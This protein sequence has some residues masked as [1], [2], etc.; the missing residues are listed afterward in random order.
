MLRIMQAEEIASL[1]LLLPDLVRQQERRSADFLPRAG[2]WL[3]SLEG[4]FAASGLYQAGSIAMLRSGLV[5]VEQGQLPPGLQFRGR[6]T[7]S[8]VL[9]AVTSQALQRAADMAS[10]LI[11]ENQPRIAEAERVAQQIVAAGLSRGLIIGRAE[12]VNNTEYLRMLRR[13]FAT[14]VDLENAVVH[15]EGLVGPYDALILID[16]ALAPISTALQ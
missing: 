7:R 3:N 5:A 15:L 9:N 2:E 1:L 12:G 8:R 13:N 16:R 10:T 4:V 14:S 11:A 6:P